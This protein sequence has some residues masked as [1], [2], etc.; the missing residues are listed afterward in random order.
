M[1]RPTEMK[2]DFIYSISTFIPS[3]WLDHNRLCNT[4]KN[5]NRNHYQFDFGNSAVCEYTN[6]SFGVIIVIFITIQF[7][8]NLHSW[9]CRWIIR[10]DG[11]SKIN[12]TAY[13]IKMVCQPLPVFCYLNGF[14]EYLEVC[15]LNLNLINI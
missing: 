14:E 6:I 10:G 15:Q 11:E 5:R 13:Q 4:I 7:N 1:V 9:S 2:I 3:Q 12:K 8:A